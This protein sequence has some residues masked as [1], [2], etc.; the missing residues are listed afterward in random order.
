[1]RV[2]IISFLI[3][4]FVSSVVLYGQVN[5][6]DVL[7]YKFN[8]TLTDSSDVIH[9]LAIIRFKSTQSANEIGFD[10]KGLNNEKKG[11]S[12]ESVTE[13]G[14]PV[15][16]VHKENKLILNFGGVL[17]ANEEKEI[18]V[19]YSGI[20][21]D[22]LIISKN[23]YGHRT[24]FSD[25]WPNRA[26]AW[27]PCNDAPGDKATVEFIITAPSH[28]QVISNGLEIEHSN[29]DENR[30]LS[31]WKEDAPLPTKIT[32]IGVAAFA[33]NLSGFANQVPVSSWVYPEDREKGFY[34]YAPAKDI[35]GF[36]MNYIGPYGYKKLANV[37]SKT[38]FGGMENASAIFYYENSVT[39]KGH[40]EDLLAHEIAHQWFGDMATEKS[41]SHLWLSEG[42]ATYMADIYLESKFGI[43]TLVKRL[44]KERREA[45]NFGKQS[46]QPVVDSVSS[47]MNLLNASSYQ[48]GA[49][50]LHMLRRQFGDSTFRKFI[51]A[52][53]ARYAGKNANTEDLRK[54]AEEISGKNLEQF[55]RQWLYTPGNPQLQVVW[56]YYEKNKSL[57]ITVSQKQENSVYKFPLEVEIKSSSGSSRI[58]KLNI[59]KQ[60]EVFTIPVKEKPSRI[61]LDPNTNL[62]FEGNAEEG[63]E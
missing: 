24:F 61:I 48:K 34:D 42:F 53:Y 22:G 12:V 15:S 3:S 49:W 33:V 5:G 16:F 54:V 28:Y 47:Y 63:K 9:G 35:L 52:Y 1:M 27:L 39:G 21:S 50:V 4:L 38:V 41:F 25:N 11:M 7:N 56:M 58:E 23:K 29:L 26:H 18:Q 6:I 43:D 8:L 57:N 10:L 45:L 19:Q 44:Q 31:H 30:T 14:K 37:Q 40:I 59:T 36:F 32:V 62:L 60:S 20:P 13:N 51:R 55:F 46:K 2:K 17:K